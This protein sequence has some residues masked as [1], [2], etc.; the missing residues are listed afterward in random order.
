MR[1]MREERDSA[2]AKKDK[3]TQKYETLLYSQEELKSNHT[4]TERKLT[5]ELEVVKADS[6]KLA[7][8]LEESRDE[9]ARVQSRLDVCMVE[10]EDLHSRLAKA[11][12]STTSA[13][14]DF[15]NVHAD[16]PSISSHFDKYVS[17]LGEHYV[18]ELFDDLRD[19]DDD[20]MGADEDD[21]RPPHFM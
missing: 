3:L 8:D 7:S 10:K 2:L 21:A 17:N 15:K 20:D 18:V 12:D 1:R 13:V 16:F 6:Q 4:T 9:L 5:L 19:D 11:E 14:E